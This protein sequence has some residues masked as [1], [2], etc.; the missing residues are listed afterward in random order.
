MSEAIIV[1]LIGSGSAIVAAVIAARTRKDVRRVRTQVENSHKTNLRDDVTRIAS[2]IDR[3]HD[4]TLQA[5]LSQD[6][7]IQRLENIHITPKE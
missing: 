4:I 2:M 3:N 6:R 7:R 1:A 5:F